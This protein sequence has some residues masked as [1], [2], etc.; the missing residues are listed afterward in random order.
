MRHEAFKEGDIE[1]PTNNIEEAQNMST[2][3]MEI[4]MVICLA[5]DN[6]DENNFSLCICS[7]E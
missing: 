6:P 1:Y 2:I 4:H 5:C 3:K 7:E